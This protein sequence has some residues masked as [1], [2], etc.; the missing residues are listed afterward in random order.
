MIE[1]AIAPAPPDAREHSRLQAVAAHRSRRRRVIALASIATVFT[2]Y[3]T[4]VAA[5]RGFFDLQVYRGAISHWV[6]GGDL[7]AY[8][9]PDTVYGFTYPPFAALAMLPMAALPWAV[10]VIVSVAASAVATVA[11]LY[12]LAAPIARRYG[13]NRSVMLA[14]A[15]TAVVGFEPIGD[16]LGFGQVNLLLLALVT[17]DLVLLTGRG[18]GS[19]G[20]LIGLATA[21]K[22]TPAIFI[23]YLLISGRRRAAA[24]ATAT[25]GGVTLTA[26]VVAPSASGEFWMRALWHTDR[27]G[28]A[29]F[30]GNQSLYGMVARFNPAHPSGLL[31]LALVGAVL[32]VWV[33]RVRAAVGSGDEKFGLALTG[34]VACLVSPITWVHHMVWLLPA[35][36]LLVD[37]ALAEPARSRRRLWLLGGAVG[38]YALLTSRVVWLF[39][40]RFTGWPAAGPGML[41]S[42]LLV[43][44]SLFLLAV[45]PA[46]P[47]RSPVPARAGGRPSGHPLPVTIGEAR[48][49]RHPGAVPRS[50]GARRHP[51]RQREA[52][53]V[54][55]QVRH[56][57]PALHRAAQRRLRGSSK[58]AARRH[59]TLNGT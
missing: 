23:A 33:V 42:N 59:P 4:V 45:T 32:A 57:R 15:A 30:V 40:P 49:R 58:V 27:V 50:A 6:R 16:T 44:V 56:G 26:A 1:T 34:I 5:Q 13:R 3:A 11:V 55:A 21:V 17:A 10:V 19:A 9:V 48:P 43:L 54:S 52:A 22:L 53:A 14:L 31:W 25:A 18:R 47:Q 35:I 7:Y 36:V 28:E 37:H 8:T 41:G 24:V 12:W 2:A 20:V 38:S 39:D 29:S 51:V 46:R